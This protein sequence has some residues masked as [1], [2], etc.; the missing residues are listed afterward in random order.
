MVIKIHI[1]LFL[2]MAYMYAIGKLD[3]FLIYYVFVIM[4]ELGHIL[5]A[6]TLK[7]DISEITLLPVGI[8]AKYESEISILRE[9]IIALAGPIA[10]FLF[11]KILNNE[12]YAFFNIVI[13]L[14]NLIP[15]FPFD[16][17]KILKNLLTLL[18]GKKIGK[19]I[20]SVIAKI[21]LCVLIIGCFYISVLCQNYYFI[22]FVFYIWC[23]VKEE[24]KKEKLYKGIDYLQKD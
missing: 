7:V 12:M 19:Q 16:G 5:I 11:Y 6:L 2:M 24:Y 8:N 14:I 23:I 17:G 9:L 18:C 4:H 3:T 15:V 22:I 21:F 20:S 10:S 1:Y 13:A